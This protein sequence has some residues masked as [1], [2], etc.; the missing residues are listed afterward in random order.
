MVSVPM[1]SDIYQG[2]E[3]CHV[4]GVVINYFRPRWELFLGAL[5][6]SLVTGVKFNQ[7][8]VNN[9]IF[10]VELIFTLDK[11]IFSH[12]PKGGCGRNS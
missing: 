10:N 8:E 11:T 6:T 5:H 12:L 2:V 7:T 1:Q 9:Q 3:L 4:A